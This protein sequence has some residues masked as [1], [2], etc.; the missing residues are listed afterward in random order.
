[1]AITQN[2]AHNFMSSMKC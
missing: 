2:Q 1:M